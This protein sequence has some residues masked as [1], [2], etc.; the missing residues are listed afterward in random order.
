[1]ASAMDFGCHV[2]LFS[3]MGSRG[4]LLAFARYA[5]A[6]G[7]GAPDALG[8]VRARDPSGICGV[9]QQ[10]RDRARKEPA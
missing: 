9:A 6:R 7:S 2:P 1:M 4:N 3:P 8:A 10:G 5:K